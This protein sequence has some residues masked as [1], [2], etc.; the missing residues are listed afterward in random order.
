MIFWTLSPAR[1]AGKLDLAPPSRSIRHALWKRSAN[2]FPEKAAEKG[3]CPCRMRK[4]PACPRQIRAAS[5]RL[6]Q[7]HVSHLARQCREIHPRGAAYWVTLEME[8]GLLRL[9]SWRDYR[10]RHTAASDHGGGGG[11]ACSTQFERGSGRA[12]Q[13]RAVAPD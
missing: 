13:E 1:E 3:A 2:F 12:R 4:G 11:P 7:I 8:A 10:A 9:L 6:K 5:A